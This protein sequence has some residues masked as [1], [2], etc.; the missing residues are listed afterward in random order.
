M[1]DA[2]S[3]DE[4]GDDGPPGVGRAV[5]V[6]FI[7]GQPGLGSDFDSVAE[8][9]GQ[10]YTVL[11]PDRPG[12]GSGLVS[13]VSMR[14]NVEVLAGLLDQRRQSGVIVVGH[15]FGGGLALLLAHHRPDLVAGLVLAAS[16]GNARELGNMDRLLALPIVGDVLVAGGLGAAGTIL[17][18]I[19]AP[20]SLAPGR[21]GRWL[22]VSLPDSSFRKAAARKQLWKSV[23]AEQ[24]T[25]MSEIG[26][27]DE[28]L[29]HIS[30]PTEVVAGTWDIM[31]GPEVAA[32]IAASVHGAELVLVPGTG[33]FLTR[34]APAVLAGAVRRVS[35]RAGLAET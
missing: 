3:P 33:H 29:R 28:A 23:V 32:H 9:L 34:D 35:E 15:S 13:P 7:H 25:L 1:P 16:V 5:A 27:I 20:A 26:D 18:V 2:A 21:L 11:A 14:E 19:R 12:Y 4:R 31:I 22:T 6:L 24:R 8:L 10:R 30:V 17:P